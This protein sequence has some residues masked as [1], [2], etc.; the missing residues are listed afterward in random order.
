MLSRVFNLS[1]QSMKRQNSL[2]KKKDFERV[3]EKG[4]GRSRHF[5]YAKTISNG[6]DI[7]RFGI[8][9]GR[10]TADK[11]VDRNLIKRRLR[12]AINSRKQRLK[13]GFDVVIVALPGAKLGTF[14]EID[15]CVERLFSAL[16]IMR[17]ALPKH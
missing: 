11:A 7:S 6:M 14:N 9:V 17:P 3:F 5:L 12:E 8:V 4:R 2:S 1:A 10:K 13:K 15:N 16:G